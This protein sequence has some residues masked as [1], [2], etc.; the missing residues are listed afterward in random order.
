M[1]RVR[2]RC[3]HAAAPAGWLRQQQQAGAGVRGAVDPGGPGV[4]AGAD[5]RRWLDGPP[6]PAPGRELEGLQAAPGADGGGL[7][8]DGDHQPPPGRRGARRRHLDQ[9][10]ERAGPDLQHPDRRGTLPRPHL[11]RIGSTPQRAAGAP[12]QGR[13]GRRAGADHGVSRASGDRPHTRAAEVGSSEDLR[14]HAPGGSGEPRRS[15]GDGAGP[16]HRPRVRAQHELGPASRRRRRS[17][18]GTSR[19]GSPRPRSRDRGRLRRPC[20]RA[21]SE[22]RRAIRTGPTCARRCPG[23][24][25]RRR[26]RRGSS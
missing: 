12:E 2:S 20:R 23:S 15:A 10:R 5:G 11:R 18:C 21:S 9:Q 25:W 13:R 17:T 3:G 6:L 8:P 22:S 14:E 4:A 24:R 26:R 16:R 1:A 7:P 19:A